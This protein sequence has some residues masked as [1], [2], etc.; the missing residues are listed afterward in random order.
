[1][2]QAA[3][4]DVD[5]T[6]EG[7]II[8]HDQDSVYT[9][10]RWLRVVLVNHRA[11]ISYS[12]NGAKGNTT[13]ESFFGRFKTENQSLFHE[14]M[15]IWELKRVIT[16]QIDYYNQRRRHST[17]LR[18]NTHRQALGNTAPMNYESQER[19]LPRLALCPSTSHR[20]K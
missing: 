8:H 2:T 20:V 16:Q 12:E 13:M 6:L 7:R 14:A 15:N 19:I 3:L 11:R 4:D 17:C 9:G 18:A 5:L 10:Y 1:V